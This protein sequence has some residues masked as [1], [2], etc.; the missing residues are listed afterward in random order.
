MAFKLVVR[1]KLRV[2]V[3]GAI[4]D[5]DGAP[6]DF[7]F[8]LLCKRLNQD[9]IDAVVKDEKK[10]V[11]QFLTEVTTG[12]DGILAEDGTP[13]AFSPEELTKV[14][15]QAGMHSVCY[16]AYLKEVGAIAKN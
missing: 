4:S 9:Q 11:R 12:W 7:D 5:D 6:V 13:L 8:V 3:K 16:G 10:S 1:N 15:L 14:L 2:P